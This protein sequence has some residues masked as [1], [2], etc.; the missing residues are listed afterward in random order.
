MPY[1]GRRDYKG[2]E[3]SKEKGCKEM[4]KFILRKY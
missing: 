2:R 3:S 4:K 1:K